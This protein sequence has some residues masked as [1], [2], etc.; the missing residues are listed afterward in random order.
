M[1]ARIGI[2]LGGTKISGVVLLADGASAAKRRTAT[3]QDDYPATVAAVV[4]LV[5]ALEAEAG[6][7][8][9]TV[10]V[11][12][13]APGT[14]QPGRARMKNCNSTWLNDRPLLAD[15]EAALGPRVRIANDADCF[16]LSEAADGAAA[17][18]AAVFGVILG[19]GVG[20]GLV[21]DGTLVQGAN[22]LVGEWGHMPLPYFRQRVFVIDPEP[23]DARRFQLESMMKDR[24]CYCGRM[25]CVETFLSGPGL[26]T[27]RGELQG[28]ASDVYR[29]MLARSLAQLVNLIDPAVIVLGGGVSNAAE[30][31]GRQQALIPRYAFSSRGG[32]EAVGV[33]V[34]RARWGDDSGVRGAARLWA[35]SRS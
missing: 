8:A 16:A 2:D 30:L 32:A 9:G 6:L 3:P 25:N 27:T 11:G 12:V 19:T 4:D 5:A 35:I 26:Q 14:W 13:G 10:S 31:C 1:T 20:G 24:G 28:E 7:P 33:H 23:D 21:L 29:H 34:Q 18:A 22:G 15:L 17:G